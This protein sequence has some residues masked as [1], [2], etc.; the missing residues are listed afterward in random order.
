MN[1]EQLLM[2]ALNGCLAIA[3]T[4]LWSIIQDLK[5]SIKEISTKCDVKYNENETH[6]DKVEAA[7]MVHQL[8]VSSR[9]VTREELKQFILSIT[10]TLDRQTDKLETR[11][12]RMEERILDRGRT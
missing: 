3:A 9:F 2:W 5:T 6:I 4:V 1:F 12:E 10:Q 11:L 7:L 8:D